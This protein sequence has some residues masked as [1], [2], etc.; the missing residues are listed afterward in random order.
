M[1]KRSHG[2]VK[3][4]KKPKYGASCITAHDLQPSVPPAALNVLN[5]ASPPTCSIQSARAAGPTWAISCGTNR[6][7]WNKGA[8][9]RTSSRI[10][11]TSHASEGCERGFDKQ[12]LTK[13]LGLDPQLDIAFRP[14][15]QRSL[16][17]VVVVSRMM[18]LAR[19][20]RPTI[21]AVCTSYTPA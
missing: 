18:L 16:E 21:E 20:T 7:S 3:H 14:Q 2:W 9:H 15:H 1:F 4:T 8:T 17:G 6:G 10:E 12:L 11:S 13:I 5:A 19:Y